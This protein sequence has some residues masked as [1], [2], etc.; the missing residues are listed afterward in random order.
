MARPLSKAE[1]SKR[2]DKGGLKTYG[3]YL[4]WW[5]KRQKAA[6]IRNAPPFPGYQTPTQ[7]KNEAESLVQSEYAPIE[8][9][10]LRQ[11][12]AEQA[13]MAKEAQAITGYAQGAAQLVAP[14]AG[15]VAQTY[16]AAA[17]SQANYAK[18]FSTGMQEIQNKAAAEAN[19]ELAKHGAPAGQMQ[20][21]TT[22]ASDVLYGVGG[23][24]PASTMSR[25]AAA[26]SSAAAML[27]ATEL[28]RGQ[29]LLGSR[30]AA[31]GETQ[32]EIDSRLS[33]LKGR[34]P[35]L[36]AQALR[37]LE[38]DQLT[39]QQDYRQLQQQERQNQQ[40]DRNLR[41]QERYLLGSE[42]KTGA[43]VTGIDPVTG[44][45]TF[46]ATSTAAQIAAQAAQAAQRAAGAAK[47]ETAKKGAA[48]KTAVANRGSALSKAREQAFDVAQGLAGKPPKRNP[49]P[50][51]IFNPGRYL[52]PGGK[53][54]NN[55][56]AAEREG[57]ATW[58]QAFA[59]VY[60][61]IDAEGLKGRYGIK[62][63]EI[64]KIIRQRLLSLGFK[65][66][67]QRPRRKP[68]VRMTGR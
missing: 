68:P 47:K 62:D 21:P 2:A 64:R 60:A 29:Q 11:Q 46:E 59:Q 10:W 50:G 28:G 65:P 6:A 20:Q 1:F 13:R 18:G 15:Q 27:P 61:A 48:R 24:I 49:D 19:A 23:Y 4:R 66:P 40:Q 9:E 8:A 3:A 67:A 37:Q 7:L 57:R 54:T 36:Y 58:S 39:A 34:Y 12:K 33:E 31:S 43:D 38:R 5:T 52:T 17:D 26:F 41:I 56:N 45:P 25:E 14:I 63:A 22:A 55:P 30:L 35:G 51:S 32:R 42:R 53:G 44:Q 16:Q